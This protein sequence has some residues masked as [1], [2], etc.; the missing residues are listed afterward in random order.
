VRVSR[1]FVFKS[2]RILED[3]DNSEQVLSLVEYE[4]G[5]GK[6]CGQ[7]FGLS[8]GEGRA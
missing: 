8:S 2:P 5:S 7:M 1:K 6:F 4:E 3:I